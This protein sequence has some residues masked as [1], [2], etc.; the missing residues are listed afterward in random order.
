MKVNEKTDAN[1]NVVFVSVSSWVKPP[2]SSGASSR[3]PPLAQY[4]IQCIA[5]DQNNCT[6]NEIPGEYIEQQSQGVEILN[7]CCYA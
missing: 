1:R 7:I 5:I 3:Y 6:R 4:V 2:R